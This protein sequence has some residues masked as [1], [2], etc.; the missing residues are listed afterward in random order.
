MSSNKY[1]GPEEII[2]SG[3]IEALRE[4]VYKEPINELMW[5]CAEHG[6]AEMFEIICDKVDEDLV[7]SAD[8]LPW[9]YKIE[10]DIGRIAKLMDL[11]YKS[12]KF[13]IVKIL[14]DR[15]GQRCSDDLVTIIDK[16]VRDA[17]GL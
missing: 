15:F 3:D 12:G 6:N 1:T 13:D 16:D 2:N 5:M 10:H 9:V 11:A 7:A 17:A 4:A 14:G 8:D